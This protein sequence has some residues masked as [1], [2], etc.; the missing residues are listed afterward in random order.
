M[1]NQYGQHLAVIKDK[2][3]ELIRDEKISCPYCAGYLYREL[4]TKLPMVTLACINLDCDIK[5]QASSVCVEDCSDMINEV[6]R[7]EKAHKWAMENNPV[8]RHLTGW[9][10][11]LAKTVGRDTGDDYYDEDK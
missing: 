8:Q 4:G 1:H 5:P 2:T 10:R 6:Y 11:I 7:E 3:F 9:K